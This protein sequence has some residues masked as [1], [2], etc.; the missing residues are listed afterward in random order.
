MH[1]C[2][3]GV[4]VGTAKTGSHRVSR[5]ILREGTNTPS[6]PIVERSRS[7]EHGLDATFNKGQVQTLRAVYKIMMHAPRINQLSALLD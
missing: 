3:G 2:T 6:F 7:P 1:A 4:C 5:R